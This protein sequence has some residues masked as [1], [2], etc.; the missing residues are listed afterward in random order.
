L[1][2]WPASDR[3][4]H[5]PDQKNVKRSLT[6]KLRLGGQAN[7]LVSAR[8]PDA[9]EKWDPSDPGGKSVHQIEVK[10]VSR[11]DDPDADLCDPDRVQ[12]PGIHRSYEIHGRYSD[13]RKANST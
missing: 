11:A 6:P 5:K 2:K 12:N 7:Q 1:C 3:P 8:L 13:L 4:L 9:I 10:G